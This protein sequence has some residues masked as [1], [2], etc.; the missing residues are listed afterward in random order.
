[1]NDFLTIKYTAVDYTASPVDQYVCATVGNITIT[2][3]TGIL[4]RVYQI[5]NQSTGSV[6]VQGSGGETVE[7]SVFKTLYSNAAVTCVFDGT[8]WKIL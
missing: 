6:K 1:M 5:K 2:L 7:G 4:G 8:I 3:P